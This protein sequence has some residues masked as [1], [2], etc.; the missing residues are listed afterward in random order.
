M[1]SPHIRQTRPIKGTA[2]AVKGHVFTTGGG[3]RVRM[4]KSV[5]EGVRLESSNEIHLEQTADGLNGLVVDTAIG[6]AILLAQCA[7]QLAA[8][9]VDA[10]VTA[11]DN[12]VTGTHIGLAD[13]ASHVCVCVGAVGETLPKWA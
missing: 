11:V 5:P 7:Q 1:C 13:P 10:H 6:D 12:D 3:Q 4:Q 2:K 8:A 9:G